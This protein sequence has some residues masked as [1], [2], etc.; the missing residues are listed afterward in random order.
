MSVINCRVQNLRPKYNNL[1]EWMNDKNNVYIARGGVLFI[2]GNRF[3]SSS[4]KWANPYKIGKDGTREEVIIKYRD[5][6]TKRLEKDELL[7]KELISL[8]GKNLGCWCY[9]EM[10]HGNVLLELIEQFLST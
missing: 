5:Y 9:P 7:Q 4:S 8:K 1:K 3:P 10:C 6:I 2:D